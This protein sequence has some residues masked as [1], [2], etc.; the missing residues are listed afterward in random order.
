MN[1]NEY[2]C[3]ESERYP[4]YITQKEMAAMLNICTS[5]AYVLQKHG[6]IPFE[7]ISTAKGR[8][9]QILTADVLRYLYEQI[10]FI[11]T[12]NEFEGMLR[13][14]FEKRLKSYPQLLRVSDIQRFTGYAKTTINNWFDRDLLKSLCHQNQQIKSSQSGKATLIRK[15]AFIDFLISPYYRTIDRKS[16][17][18]R[19]QAQDYQKLFMSFLAKRGVPNG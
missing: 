12:A 15:G 6:Q 14:F 10:C 1:Y 16:T 4:K 18:H 8:R 2:I 13:I 17:L 7:Y 5:K 3:S 11:E 9:Q 19:E